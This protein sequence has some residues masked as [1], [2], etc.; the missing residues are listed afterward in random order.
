MKGLKLIAFLSKEDMIHVESPTHDTEP[1]PPLYNLTALAMSLVHSKSPDNSDLGIVNPTLRGVTHA[2]AAM[3]RAWN[4][5][6]R[7]SKSS[8]LMSQPGRYT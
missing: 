1:K 6:S 8:S 7:G 2:L 4:L 5:W 3:R